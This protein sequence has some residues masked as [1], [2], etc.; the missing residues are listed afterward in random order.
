MKLG[1]LLTVNAVVAAV[2][3]IAFIAAPGQLLEMYA[4]T[5]NP[6]SAVVARL[7]GASLVGYAV[8]SWASRTAAPSEALKAITIGYFIGDL[9]GALLSLHGVLTG[10]TNGLGWSTV[11]IYALL[12]AGFGSFTFGKGAPART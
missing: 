6:G 8:I 2:F 10:A 11:A 3:A 12:G 4:V 5:L 9:F 1:M 7:F